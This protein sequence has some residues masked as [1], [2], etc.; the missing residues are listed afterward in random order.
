MI[1]EQLPKIK[2]TYKPHFIIA[3][4]ENISHGK[5]I[6]EKYYKFLLEQGVNVVTLGNHTWDNRSIFDFIDDADKLV[7]PA[8]FPESNPG[9]GLTFVKFNSHEVAVISIQGRTFMPMINC[10]FE[11]VEQLVE[12]AKKRTNI[13]FVDFHAEATSEKVAMGYFLDG[14][15][16]AVV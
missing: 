2:E 4:G 12:E 10:P 1:Q 5:G 6:N 7:R 13:I 11:K 9:K 14:R 16:S 3:N 8:N 15:V